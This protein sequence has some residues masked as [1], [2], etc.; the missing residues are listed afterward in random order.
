MELNNELAT[1]QA[2]VIAALN[3]EIDG[4]AS[5]KAGLNQS[6]AWVETLDGRLNGAIVASDIAR[7]KDAWD[8]KREAQLAEALP[9]FE[10]EVLTASDVDKLFAEFVSEEHDSTRPV[11]LEYELV[12]AMSQ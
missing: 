6:L 1:R 12:R 10:Q 9:D 2:E 5:S 8:K 4:F 11:V 7:V 3:A